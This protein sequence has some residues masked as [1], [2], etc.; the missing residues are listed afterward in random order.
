M[1]PSTMERDYAKIEHCG[2]FAD[3]IIN[4]YFTKLNKNLE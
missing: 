1:E 2:N 3:F 4:R